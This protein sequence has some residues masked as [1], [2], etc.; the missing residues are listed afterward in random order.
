MTSPPPATPSFDPDNIL[1]LEDANEDV[2]NEPG[3]IGKW[4]QRLMV[5][6]DAAEEGAQ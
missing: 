3:K 2:A 5:A 4:F 6:D 1:T